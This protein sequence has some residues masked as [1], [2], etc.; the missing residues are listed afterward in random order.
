MENVATYKIIRYEKRTGKKAVAYFTS[1]KKAVDFI[2][3]ILTSY[4]KEKT[5]QLNNKGLLPIDCYYS[6]K[7]CYDITAVV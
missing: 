7:Y 3:S 5:Q 4:E 1:Y 6:K 2:N